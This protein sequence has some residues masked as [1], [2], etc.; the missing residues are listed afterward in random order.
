MG[1]PLRES[2]SA[3]VDRARGFNRFRWPAIAAAWAACT[4]GWILVMSIQGRYEAK[5]KVFVETT[6]ALAPVIEGL[7]IQQ[8]VGAQLA[9]VQQSMLGEVNLDRII[10]ATSFSTSVKTTSD[11]A[12]VRDLLRKRIQIAVDASANRGPGGAAYTIT[13]TDPDRVRSLQ[14]V[15][16]LLDSLIGDTVGGKQG[17]AEAARKFLTAR[18]QEYESKLRAAETRLAEFKKNNVGTMP[19]AEGDYFTRLQNEVDAERQTRSLLAVATSRR[20][21]LNRQLRDGSILTSSAA[22]G[23]PQTVTLPGGRMVASGDTITRLGDAEAKLSALLQSYTDKHPEVIELRA[24]IAELKQKRELELAALRRGDQDAVLSTGVTANPVYQSVRVALNQA[25]VEV[26]ALRRSL[27]DHETKVAELRQLINTVP[28][29]EAEFARLNRDYDLDKAQYLAL[30]ER[31]EKARIGNFA[32]Q[33]G[34]GSRFRVLDP[35]T[36]SQRPVAPNRSRLITGV[37]LASMLGAALLAY[38]LNRQNPVFTTTAEVAAKFGLPVL[39][40]VSLVQIEQH[41]QS[42]R[43]SNLKFAATAAG[44]VLAFSA[45]LLISRWLPDSVLRL[46]V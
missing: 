9:L 7:A 44:L 17:D 36:A 19:G 8:D 12:A 28:Q 3:W 34:S 1:T 35:P 26:A 11:R 10:D 39:G 31:L 40:V 42:Q 45:M 14:V 27:A 13:Y 16:M 38:L 24:Q 23:P 33:T 22:A 18:I 43:R 21:E 32:E 20:D 41:R 37:F 25:E 46:F 29:S 30:V 5:S 4:L 15:R 2:L 6:T